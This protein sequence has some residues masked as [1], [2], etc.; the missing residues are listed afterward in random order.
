MTM[1]TVRCASTWSAP[2]WLSSSVTKIAD[3]L[4]IELWEIASTIWPSA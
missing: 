4:Q 2:S 1:P 3:E